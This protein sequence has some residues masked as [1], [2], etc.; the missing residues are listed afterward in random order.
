MAAPATA[1]ICCI[2]VKVPH[3]PDAEGAAA[4][5]GDPPLELDADDATDPPL[6]PDPPELEPGTGVTVPVPSVKPPPDDP[7][8]LVC[9]LLGVVLT[10]PGVT[11]DPPAVPVGV[12]PS[13][14]QVSGS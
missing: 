12:P 13:S 8:P 4:L 1:S 2:G 11:V 7:D 5:L 14:W 9:T 3:T 10:P 6:E